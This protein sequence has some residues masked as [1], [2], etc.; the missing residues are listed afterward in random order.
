MGIG[1]GCSSTDRCTV[2][3]ESLESANSSLKNLIKLLYMAG[4]MMGLPLVKLSN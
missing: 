4:F 2:S 1:A 3:M